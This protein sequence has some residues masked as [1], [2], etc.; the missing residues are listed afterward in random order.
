VD[1]DPDFIELEKHYLAE[2]CP[3]IVIV[4][5]LNA[6]EAIRFLRSNRADLIVSNFRMPGT[7][8]VELTRQVRAFDRDV[9]L[10]L[11]SENEVM[12]ASLAAGASAFMP[13][14]LFR[15]NHRAVIDDLLLNRQTAP[16]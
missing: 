13:K 6:N 4:S 1:D 16:R 8:G 9:P 7:S 14:D 3:D 10:L 5:F 2:S 12:N 11:V 15:K